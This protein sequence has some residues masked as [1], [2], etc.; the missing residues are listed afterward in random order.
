MNCENSLK[1]IP[2]RW[3]LVVNGEKDGRK[4]SY[5]LCR[6]TGQHFYSYENLIRYVNHAKEAKISIYSPNFEE[7]KL[8]KRSAKCSRKALSRN[9]S[10]S[11]ATRQGEEKFDLA[12]TTE[13]AV[14]NSPKQDLTGKDSIL[15]SEHVGIFQATVEGEETLNVVKTDQ[16]AELE[17]PKSDVQSSVELPSD[18]VQMRPPARDIRFTYFRKR[19]YVRLRRALFNRVEALPLEDVDVSFLAKLENLIA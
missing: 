12:K 8:K 18:P 16:V 10:Q 4:L 11:S 19:P 13:T 15:A 3:E 14:P 17:E 6:E 1:P 7:N 2:E 5:Y 9:R